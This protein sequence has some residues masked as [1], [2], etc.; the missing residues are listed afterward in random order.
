MAE[1]VTRQTTAPAGA[2]FLSYASED[3]EAAERIA[4]TLRAAGIEVWFDRSELRGGDA[5][6]HTIHQQIHA[7]SL[8][9]PVISAHTDERDEGYFRREWNLA[10]ERTADMAGD[11]PFLLPVVID[12]TAD[13]TA[14]VPDKF[15]HIHWTRLPDGN[16]PP[17]FV[18]RVARLLAPHA[19]ALQRT[20]RAP[21]VAAARGGRAPGRPGTMRWL[22]AG[23]L[24]LV[25]GYVVVERHDPRSPAA[26]PGQHAPEKSIAVLPFVD[27]SEKHDQEYFADGLSEEL[28]DHL[29]HAPDLKVIARTS[30]FKFKGKSDDIRVIASTLGVDHVLEGSVR[31]SGPTLR[32]TAQLIR[33][34]DGVHLWSQAYDRNLVDI[35]KVQNEIA[36]KV[37]QALHVAMLEGSPASDRKPD[38]RAYNLLLEGNYFNARYNREDCRRAAQ[39]Y[40]QALDIDP[41][42]ALAW[43]RLASA[44]LN[45][46]VLGGPPTEDQNRRILDALDR[47]LRLDPD[48]V[49]AYYTRGGFEM[50]VTWNWAAAEA[51][52]ERM[53]AIDPRSDLL[54]G[55]LG[56]MAYTFAEV[57]KAMEF[58]Q[59]DIERNPLDPAALDS[60]GAAYC[61][62]GRL[63]QCLQIRLRALQ[64]HPEFGG[65]NSSVGIARL[66]L[67]Q[68]PSALAAMQVE[69]NEEYRLGCLAIVYFAMGR[70]AESDAA[71]K[72]LTA[73]FSASGAYGIAEVHAFRGEIDAAFQ[74]LDQAYRQHNAGMLGVKADPLLRNL[75][76]D[77]RFHA[78]L[79]RMGLTGHR[80]PEGEDHQA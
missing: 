69:P 33:A 70:H 37:S 57:A 12:G 62:A 50:N 74:W 48:L 60:L 40:Q 59:Q 28:I 51:A 20:P 66:L 21:E 75:H 45:M 2:V 18:D 41:E 17:A 1:V 78:L 19:P 10:V 11:K 30:S 76:A 64:M 24:V 42:Y 34:S 77:P 46:E 8:F 68:L 49:W 56:D 54:P 31:K 9:L 44:Y 67:G 39:L 5:W 14:R 4:T 52:T 63:Q 27:M 79:S 15:R 47:A 32:I 26:S 71:L 55:A 43:A 23:L 61:A 65:V 53:R 6:D 73:K 38:L 22:V 72:S 58:Y 3:V 25:A 80:Q 16:T 29:A 35:F 36:E 13:A 7:C